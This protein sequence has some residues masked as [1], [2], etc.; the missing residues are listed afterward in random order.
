MTTSTTTARR[1]PL[2]EAIAVA[3][4]GLVDDGRTEAK[5]EPTHGDLD[6]W[7]K[8][9]GLGPGDPRSQK[10]PVGKF[11]RVRGALYWA[12]DHALDA[13][14]LAVASLL[15]VVRGRGG[16][17]EG[18]S[19]FVGAEAIATA[20]HA[21]ASEGYV[22]GTDGELRPK[23]LDNLSGAE[24]T[25]ALRSYAQRAKRGIEDAA[26]SVG[27]GKDLLEATAAHVLR[28]RFGSYPSKDNFPTLLGQ[29][30]VAVGLATP[31]HPEQPGEHARRGVERSLYQLGCAVNRLRNKEGTGHGRPCLPDLTPG[32]AR[33]AVEAMGIIAERLL[34]ALGG[35]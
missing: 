22:L 29:A 2:T 20:R 33:L 10:E 6:L 32:E 27:T 21:F 23:V 13:G 18:S 17:R 7:V 14:E 34:D 9:F 3:V 19:N 16:F 25:D 28:E 8:R 15:E 30:F 4:A 1:G 12:L 11:K 26:L 35:M 24:M 31:E 5:R